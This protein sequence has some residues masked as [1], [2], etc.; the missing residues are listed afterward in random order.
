VELL[1]ARNP[2]EES[3]LPY[4]LR[5]PIGDG[6]VLRVRDTW[7]R[8]KAI[9][10]HPVTL[11]EW[12][13]DPEIVVREELRACRR[14]GAAIDVVLA[15]ARENRSQ[16]VFTKARGRDVVFWQSPRTRKQ[17]RPNVATPK[18]VAPGAPELT[19]VIDTRE[20]YAYRFSDK[21]VAT[22]KQALPVGDYGAE[23][24]DRLVAVVERKSGEDLLTSLSSGKLRFAMAELATVPRAAV[25]VEQRYSD[26][27]KGK[28]PWL[29]PARAADGI[30]ELAVRWPTVPIL[31]LESRSMAEEY[32][33]R[34]L[35]AARLWAL[36]DS[37]VEDRLAVAQAP[38]TPAEPDPANPPVATIRAW[39]LT[40]GL[41]VSQRGRLRPEVVR[42]FHEA[43]G[44]TPE[45]VPG[46]FPAETG[47]GG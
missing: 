32:V 17:A 47:P 16:I 6:M 8:T 20:R 26:V 36:D 38:V 30:A 31:F 41:P 35:A 1:I 13:D 42:A 19:I 43:R 34:F 5:L 21:P 29:R 44:Q 46:R 24:D 9:Y 3:S 45:A 18:G 28:Q 22:R 33:Y 27:F 23:I 14:S 12:P 40:N 39:A 25:V 10:C 2:Y 37:A 4:L 15:R 7:P 11:D